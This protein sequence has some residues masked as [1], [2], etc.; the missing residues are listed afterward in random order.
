MS[1]AIMFDPQDRILILAPHPD[2]EVLGTGGIIQEAMKLNLP[3]RI[4][5][6]TYGDS[7]EWSFLLYRRHPVLL[8]KGARNMGLVRHDEA[9]EAAKALGV[10][11]P[12]LTFLGYPDFGT[13][14]I[15][16][17]HWGDRPPVESILTHAGAVPYP[18]AFRPG[19][20]YKGEEIL[21]DLEK[22][23][24]EFRPTKIFVSHPGD[25]N[26]DH[27]SLYLFLRV[28]LWDLENEI[29]P[30][31]YPYLVHYRQWPTPRGYR[32][33]DSLLPPHELKSRIQWQDHDLNSTEI[34]RKRNALR[35][36]R[37]QYEAN[38]R[39]LLSFVR[40]NEI[41]G[42]FPD[43]TLSLNAGAIAISPE[44]HDLKTAL[45]EQLL[46]ENREAFVGIQERFVH[47]ENGRF[48]LSIR[49]SRPLGGQVGASVYVFGYRKDLSFQQMPKL[50]IKLGELEH[51]IYDQDR[52]LPTD[53]IR[54]QR[55]AEEVILDV[56][57]ELLGN[58]ERILTSAHTYF[59]GLVPLD[60]GSWRVLKVVS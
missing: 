37:S 23:L 28:V 54:V 42:D 38:R 49:W 56:P 39:Y 43:T 2:D 5:F 59:L 7:N 8:P 41:F 34:E 36:H 27:K 6:L 25:H 35:K 29:N 4:V 12:Q 55:R 53:A 9:L 52:T 50:H 13:L 58:P 17:S 3:L 44:Y 30:V 45:P 21:A 10:P 32:P 16:C 11:P 18:N 48:V 15:W 40:S 1:T 60:G 14:D 33:S 31:V 20:P 47:I 46:E 19:A 22:T 24:L 51:R 26:S 57:L